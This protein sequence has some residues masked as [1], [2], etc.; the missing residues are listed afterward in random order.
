MILSHRH[1]LIF[2][3]R[4]KAAGSS[5]ELALAD[6]CGDDDIITTLFEGEEDDPSLLQFRADEAYKKFGVKR[7][8][9]NYRLTD[10]PNIKGIKKELKE[11]PAKQLERMSLWGNEEIFWRHQ[12]SKAIKSMMQDDIYNDY[13]KFAIVRNPFDKAISW[14]YHRKRTAGLRELNPQTSL[15]FNQQDYTKPPYHGLGANDNNLVPNSELDFVL[16]FENLEEDIKVKLEFNLGLHGLWDKFKDINIHADYRPNRGY[17][18][19]GL[20]KEEDIREHY[21]GAYGVRDFVL[22]HFNE[23]IEKYNYPIPDCK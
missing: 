6:F 22:K 10:W 3:K 20:T 1:R 18:D 13:L 7:R 11:P 21:R 12:Q 16:R 23:T 19:R 2:F 8:A 17:I 9:Q 14:F 15:P 5:F 4:Y